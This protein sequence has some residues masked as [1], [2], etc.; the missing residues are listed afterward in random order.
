[1]CNTSRAT[2]WTWLWILAIW[3]NHEHIFTKYVGIN[4][5]HFKYVKMAKWE[6]IW[7][8]LSNMTTCIVRPTIKLSVLL[9][10][11]NN[12]QSEHAHNFERAN[13]SFEM[14]YVTWAFAA[15]E[16]THKKKKIWPVVLHQE[17]KKRLNT[18]IL[19]NCASKSK[20]QCHT[21]R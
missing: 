12:G 9:K 7:T 13:E 16:I 3:A 1:M 4:D 2:N 10:G 14:G 17:G 15:L 6:N 20:T 5:K 21:K 8:I 11:N 19:K 18:H